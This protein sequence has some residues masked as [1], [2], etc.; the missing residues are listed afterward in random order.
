MDLTKELPQERGEDDFA[1]TNRLLVAGRERGYWRQCSIGWHD[2]CSV[3]RGYAAPGA[4]K[5]PCHTQA[6]EVTN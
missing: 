4:C 2:E 3:T 6:S 5:C 1:W